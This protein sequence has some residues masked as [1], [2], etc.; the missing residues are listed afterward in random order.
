MIEC[1]VCAEMCS[2]SATRCDCGARLL[3]TD[4]FLAALG[5]AVSVV[6]GDPCWRC[7]NC[8]ILFSTPFCSMCG[9]SLTHE[10][11]EVCAGVEV[12]A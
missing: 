4:A 1:P 5:G 3:P 7:P 8:L 2:P 12:V 9:A 6:L 10:P 11:M